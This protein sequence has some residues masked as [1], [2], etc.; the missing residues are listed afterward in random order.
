VKAP[1]TIVMLLLALTATAAEPRGTV[2]AQRVDVLA[3]ALQA[4]LPALARDGMCEVTRE[5]NGWDFG[6]RLNYDKISSE[7]VRVIL[8]AAS[9]ETSEI[10]VQGVRIE[11]GLISSRR[12]LDPEL[13]KEWTGRILKLIESPGEATAPLPAQP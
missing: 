9:A 12:S 4:R 6:I 11:G 1:L 10:R 8:R 5:G 7:E 2:V 13:S 3:K